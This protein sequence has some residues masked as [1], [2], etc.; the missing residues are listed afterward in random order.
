[1]KNMSKKNE[2]K[3]ITAMVISLKPKKNRYC[4]FCRDLAIWQVTLKPR[5]ITKSIWEMGIEPC[6]LC[7]RHLAMIIEDLSYRLSC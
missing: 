6:N 3:E 4:Y 1:M 7:Y 5:E 2:Y